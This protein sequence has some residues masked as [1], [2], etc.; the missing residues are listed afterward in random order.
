MKFSSPW[1][2]YYTILLTVDNPEF[3]VKNDD[4][5]SLSKADI[6]NVKDEVKRFDDIFS[7]DI[8]K[9]NGLCKVIVNNGMKFR[10][11]EDILNDVLKIIN[12]HTIG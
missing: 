7:K 3:C 5:K 12:Y 11:K 8:N 6:D 2:E 1:F 9:S 10:P 4:G